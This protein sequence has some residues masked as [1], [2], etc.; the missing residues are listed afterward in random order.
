MLGN[1]RIDD[2]PVGIAIIVLSVVVSLSCQIIITKFLGKETL[3]KS[4]EVGGYYLS[5]VG[6]TYAV[7]LGLVVFDAMAKFQRAEKIVETEAKSI[8]AIFS[9]SEQFSKEETIIKDL[10]RDYVDEVID[11]EWSMMGNGQ[12]SGKKLNRTLKTS[13]AFTPLFSRRRSHYGKADKIEPD[14]QI[15]AF[16]RRNG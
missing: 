11:N 6:T 14:Q 15:L 3:R 2:Y 5:L 12:T 4:H 9:L 10:I 16:P 8:I 13:K 1:L 7:L